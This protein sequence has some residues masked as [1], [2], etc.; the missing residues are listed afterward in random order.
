[1]KY[2]SVVLDTHIDKVLDYSVP[3]S[4]LTILKPGA[5]IETTLRGRKMRGY[6][7]ALKDDSDVPRVKPLL[8]VLPENTW[9]RPELF[10][11]G[12]WMAKYYIASLDQV[13]KCMIPPSI[14]KEVKA[15]TKIYLSLG[16]TKQ[17]LIEAVKD[18]RRTFPAQSAALEYLLKE[19]GA[20]Q[21]DLTEEL[22]ISKSPI[23]TLLKKKLIKSKKIEASDSLFENYFETK[24]KTLKKE[25]QKA[26]EEIGKTL[27]EKKFQVHLLHGITGSG[28][29][30]VYMQ[31]MQKAI[32]QG[33]SV[34]VLVPEVALTSQLIEK[35]RARF[36]EPIAIL[37]HKRSLGER[38]SDWSKIL[39]GKAPIVLGARSAIFSPAKDL[40]LIIIDEEHDSSY[41][42]TEEAPC[43]QARDVAI[44]RAKMQNACVVLGSATPSLESFYKAEKG[45]YALSSMTK[46]AANASL[47]KVKI[48]DMV[49]EYEKNGGYTHF[50]NDLLEGIK[51]RYQKGEQTLLFLN[52]RG[53]HA[54]QACTSCSNIISCPHCDISLTYHKKENILRCHLCDYYLPSPRNCP[55]CS[56]LDTFKFK[57]FGTEHIER[58][59]NAILPDIRTL[60]MDRD[61]T[62]K[63][64]SHEDL[65]DAFRSGKADVLIGTQMIAK[66][67]HFPSVSLVGVLNS[68]GALSIP[69]FR[70][71][72]NVFQLITQVA[73]RAGREEI[74]GEVIIQTRMP[75]HPVIKLA[76]NQDYLNFYKEELES[77]KLF[78]F[79]PFSR[80][81]KLTFSSTNEKGAK[82][83]AE[84][85]REEVLKNLSPGDKIHPVIPAIHAKVKD[86]FRFQFLIRSQK[87]LKLI[88]N[89]THVKAHFQIPSKVRLLID[90]DPTSG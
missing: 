43:Y 87:M 54:S 29:T 3:S 23:D 36:K 55:S 47:P 16:K 32:D 58:S 72:E 22:K 71:P 4:L 61:T 34:I 7:Y 48:L 20:Y 70:A 51:T 21:H 41:K 78:L 66:G 79:P 45:K 2:A 90:V 67:F 75:Q 85:F 42:Q 50:S 1:M 82:Q 44:M 89:V 57:G 9:I 88:E 8:G 86:R 35:F 46:R 63:K 59:L 52:R 14:R 30:E 56:S 37:H 17:T 77:R 83:I 12:L 74:D 26:F 11:L 38:S 68:D 24:P 76:M 80:M 62:R 10:K 19:N 53:F 64:T 39:E 65:F 6:I 60:R 81:I 5:R 33:Q 18:L 69:D 84:H 31:L 49:K 13:F 25:Q 27:D 15:R 40:G 73:G 28:K